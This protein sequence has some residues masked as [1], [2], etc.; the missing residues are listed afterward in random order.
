P[1]PP[2][3]RPH[4]PGGVQPLPLRGDR[5]AARLHAGGGRREHRHRRPDAGAGGGQEPPRRRRPDVAG[6]VRG[7]R[8]RAGREQGGDDTGPPPGARGE[9]LAAEA[10]ARISSYDQA[11]SP[12][13]AGRLQTE[14]PFPPIL[15]LRYVRRLTLRY[16]E[17]PHQQAAF[18]LA[19]NVGHACV[20]RA[21][22][23]HGKELS[24]NNLLHLAR[25]LDQ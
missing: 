14:G 21:E 3:H 6:P 18:Y 23:L 7:P 22:V 4:R 12:W 16:G 15:E 1:R 13:F 19:P 10:F 2:R 8:P 25:A 11:I 17:N 20:A 5:G 24:Y 9:R